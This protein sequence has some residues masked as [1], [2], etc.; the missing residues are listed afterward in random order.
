MSDLFKQIL[1]RKY[2]QYQPYYIISS[3]DDLIQKIVYTINAAYKCAIELTLMY[4]YNDSKLLIL[5]NFDSYQMKYKCLK[6]I[7]EKTFTIK[8]I[9]HLPLGKS[10]IQEL[11]I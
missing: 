8:K 7:E 10:S 6:T 4:I 3:H 5:D 9:L 2:P 11:D 1:Y